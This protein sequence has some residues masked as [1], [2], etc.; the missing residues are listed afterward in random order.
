[1]V[2]YDPLYRPTAEE[3]PDSDDTPVDDEIALL[4]SQFVGRDSGKN[5][6]GSHRLVLCSQH[7]GVL[8]ARTNAASADRSRWILEFGRAA[9]QAT[10]RTAIAGRIISKTA[11]A[12]H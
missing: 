10:A 12:G 8:C 2:Q 4:D 3:L 11:S 6:G 5:L 7:G 9:S 1:M